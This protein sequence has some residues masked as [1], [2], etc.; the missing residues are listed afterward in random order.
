M[1][2]IIDYDAGNLTSVKRAVDHLG[3]PCLITNDKKV[4]GESE[5]IIFPG[6]G[7]A[8]AAM[9]SLKKYGL[10]IEIKESVKEGKPLLGICIGTQIIMAY[11]EENDTR[12]L[13]IINGEVRSFPRNL[14]PEGGDLLKNPHMGWNG[15]R[16]RVDHPVFAGIRDGDEFYFVHSYYPMPENDQYVI[17]ETDYGIRFPSVIGKDNVVAMQFHVEKSGRPGLSILKNFC[18]WKP[19]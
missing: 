11:S 7:A 17:G 14:T 16:F 9:E 8:G 2:A 12:C 19:C 15:V 13:G 4:I 1:I 5:K 6:V 3:Y 18:E 10:D